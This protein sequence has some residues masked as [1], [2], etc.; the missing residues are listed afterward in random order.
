MNQQQ[1]VDYLREENRVLRA[2]IL[3]RR[4]RLGDNQ[5]RLL[6]D[7]ESG[8]GGSKADGG[9]GA[10]CTLFLQP[11]SARRAPSIRAREYLHFNEPKPAE[12]GCG[13]H[14]GLGLLPIPLV[15]MTGVFEALRL[16][17]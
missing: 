16:V 15:L 9:C 8:V 5:R 14:S 6:G 4:L 3:T 10:G 7:T 2:Q 11:P 17:I 13:G 12:F 1:I